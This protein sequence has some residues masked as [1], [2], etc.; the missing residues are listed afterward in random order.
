MIAF[1]KE[2]FSRRPVGLFELQ[3]VRVEKAGAGLHQL[4]A[5]ELAQLGH[6]PG[7]LAHDRRFEGPQPIEIDLRL[8]EGDAPLRGIFGLVNQFGDVQQGFRR[9][10]AAVQADA[11]G[12]GL[13]VDERDVHAAIGRVERRRIARR[14]SADHDDLCTPCP[15]CVDLSWSAC[16]S[17]EAPSSKCRM[18]KHE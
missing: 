17:R 16:S 11:A 13:V 1:P 10:A 14:P 4:D 2:S 12:D 15:A 5:A 8:G 18:T 3:G 7:E 9:D 6:A